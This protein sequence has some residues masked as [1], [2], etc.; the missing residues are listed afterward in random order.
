[1]STIVNDDTIK[2]YLFITN[3]LGNAKSLKKPLRKYPCHMVVILVGEF[4]QRHFMTFESS[5][6]FF[7]EQIYETQDKKLI[8]RKVFH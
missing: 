2:L 1:M 5:S 6:N 8:I 7:S 4:P 3:P